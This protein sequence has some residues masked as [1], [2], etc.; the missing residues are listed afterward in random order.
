MQAHHHKD[1]FIDI[2][3]LA[4]KGY[5]APKTYVLMFCTVTF[6]SKKLSCAPFSIYPSL[7]I[8]I[9]AYLCNYQ[10]RYSII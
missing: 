2:Y 8:D 1:E 10:S 6:A 5:L 3:N 4:N 7:C 9:I